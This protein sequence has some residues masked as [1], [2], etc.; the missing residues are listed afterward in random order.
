MRLLINLRGEEKDLQEY[1]DFVEIY[2]YAFKQFCARG[3]KIYE[4]FS[5][6]CGW[7]D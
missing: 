4:I 6:I 7:D 1:I 3:V 2:N 5:F